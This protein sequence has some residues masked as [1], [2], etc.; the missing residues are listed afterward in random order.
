MAQHGP[1]HRCRRPTPRGRS[2]G[3]SLLRRPFTGDMTDGS[4]ADGAAQAVKRA[5]CAVESKHFK[6]IE[7]RRPPH[8]F[9]GQDSPP[10]FGRLCAF[11]E[12]T[13]ARAS[14]EP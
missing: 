4:R 5:N 11:C 2:P 3:S 12:G 13:I 7:S 6:L 9:R 1:H 8:A 10:Q 14:G